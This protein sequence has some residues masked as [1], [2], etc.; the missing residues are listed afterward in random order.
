MTSGQDSAGG[1]VWRPLLSGEQRDRAL[2]AIGWLTGPDR[3]RHTAAPRGASLASGSAGLAVCY[4]IL[5]G[6]EAADHADDLAAEYLDAAINV[7]AAEPLTTSL[8][9]GFPG[10]AWAASLIERLGGTDSLKGTDSQEADADQGAAIDAALADT[11]RHYPQRGPYDLIDGLAGLGAYAVARW[12]RPAAVECLSQVIER[13]AR[14]ARRDADG[15]YWWTPPSLMA[16]ARAQAYPDGG[17]DL[18][19]AHGVAG[20][21]PLLARAHVL[22]VESGTAA[23]LLDGAIRWMLARLVETPSGRTMPA[24]VAPDAE[25]VPARSAWCYGDPGVAVA[26]LLAAR[27]TG[28]A[29]WAAA[30]TELALRAARRPPEQTGVAD[31]GV[32]HGSAGLAHMFGRLHQMTGERELADAASFWLGRTLW[33]CGAPQAGSA[34]GPTGP[35]PVRPA[36]KEA[37]LLEGAAGVALVLHAACF[38][39][40]PAWDQ[41]LLVSTGGAGL[42]A[43]AFAR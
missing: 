17:V 30:G 15:V 8:Y 29:S 1:A 6:T 10:I 40:G 19:V 35:I 27:D 5:A 13:L 16:S 24:F 28:E 41:M 42:P 14:R 20:V 36:M 11:L 9:S 39:A 23:P 18:G 34:G 3:D 4:A 7:L 25:P 22:G 31:A 43:G 37:G 2:A 32:C 12:P 21:I 26:L 38:A 33:L